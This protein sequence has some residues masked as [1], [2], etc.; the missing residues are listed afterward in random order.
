MNYF[1]R[2]FKHS[3]RDIIE[4]IL[5][6]VA[7]L[8]ALT[9]ILFPI[10]LASRTYSYEPTTE[11]SA[12]AGITKDMADMQRSFSR[13]EVSE[14]DVKAVEAYVYAAELSA[15]KDEIK[16]RENEQQ[17]LEQQELE[18]S[19]EECLINYFGYVPSDEELEDFYQIVM[20]ESGNTEPEDGIG[21][22]A[23]VVAN[24][25]R[26]SKFPDTIDGVIYQRNQFQP[27]GDGTFGR[28]EVTDLVREICSDHIENGPFYPSILYFTAGRY[29]GSGTPAFVIG[30]HY[31][32]Y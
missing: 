22:V 3:K 27:V 14:N 26:S 15:L 11:T 25:C 18:K 1:R 20:D 19:R 4:E 10:I 29:N 24:R 5:I 12:I 13:T 6:V 17:E 32:S 2:A 7:L 9:A 21:A 8:V 30:N 23:D 16:Q 28:F 31:F